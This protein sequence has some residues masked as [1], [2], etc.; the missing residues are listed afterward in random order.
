[1]LLLM[2]RVQNN[3]LGPHWSHDCHKLKEE[4]RG[5]GGEGGREPGRRGGA[6]R[7]EIDRV[8]LGEGW[9]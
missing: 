9:G 4:G 2:I 1:M 3:H 6:W 7:V 8:V 5:G